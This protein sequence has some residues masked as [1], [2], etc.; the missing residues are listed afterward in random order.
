MWFSTEPPKQR[1]YENILKFRTH[2]TNIRTW[3]EREPEGPAADTDWMEISDFI[4]ANRQSIDSQD[5]RTTADLLCTKFPRICAV[6]IMS[7]SAHLG[8]LLYPRWP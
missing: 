2:N 3:V 4:A 1:L 5:Y 7:G 6:E 8:V